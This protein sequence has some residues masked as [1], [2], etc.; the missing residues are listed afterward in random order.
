ME[1][2]KESNTVNDENGLHVAG[3]PFETTEED[4]ILFFKDYKIENVQLV[5]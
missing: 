1:G 4:L 5:K 3:L 2:N